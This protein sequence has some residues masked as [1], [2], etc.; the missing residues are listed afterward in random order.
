VINIKKGRAIEKWHR[1]QGSGP[2]R[3]RYTRPGAQK[4]IQERSWGLQHQQ[5]KKG[6]VGEEYQERERRK[7]CV[8][9]NKA[10]GRGLGP[11]DDGMPRGVG[12]GGWFFGGL[13][14]FL[15]EQ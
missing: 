10:D 9:I 3:Q 14:A 1:C 4:G 7:K 11:D 6:A 5:S 15:W 12:G 2:K 13:V 8:R